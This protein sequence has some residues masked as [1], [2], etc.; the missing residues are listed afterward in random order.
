MPGCGSQVILCG[1]PVRFD[2]YIGCSHACKYCFVQ[3]KTDI[4]E[5]KAGETTKALIP[6]IEG[7][8]TQETAW[9]DWPIPLHWGGL[10]D[11]FQP[12]EAVRRN[13]Y[14]C[15]QV[16]A[17]TKYP[18]V[19]STKGRLAAE[20]EYL[21]LLKDCN[22]V[23]QI[24]MACSR[25]DVMEQGAPSFEERLVMV[26]KLAAAVPRVIIRV[27]PYLCEVFEDVRANMRRFR[28]AGAYGVVIEGMKFA[29]R[30][31]GLVKIAGDYAYPRK[32]LERDFM[33]LR[34]EAHKHGLKFYCG[35]NR[36]RGMGDSLTCCGVDGHEGFCPNEFN[37]CHIMNG[38][39]TQATAAMKRP[40][41]AKCFSTLNQT[42][43]GNKNLEGKTFQDAML[44][45]YLDRKAYIHEIFGKA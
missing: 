20:P 26:E 21:A 45:Y 8:R 36:L 40:D 5:I 31:P 37:L 29:K 16:F 17:K 33:R 11:P 23:V 1:L 43:A 44:R 15:L 32:T 18:F 19:V 12:V 3:R 6:F 41:T 2:T 30:K 9:C 35:E 28:E 13:S 14:E 39:K 24:S 25:Y 22:C 42:S 38:C 7:Q 4:S 10:S 34:D 27:Q